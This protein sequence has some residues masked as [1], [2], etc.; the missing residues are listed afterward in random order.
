[1][2][3]S[4]QVALTEPSSRPAKPPWPWLPT[5]GRRRGPPAGPSRGCPP[6][7]W[8]ALLRTLLAEDGIEGLDEESLRILGGVPVTG[9]RCAPAAGL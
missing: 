4:A 9:H 1:V 7:P 3:C 5:T 8:S 2:A 6:G